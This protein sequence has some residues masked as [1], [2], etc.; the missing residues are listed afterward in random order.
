MPA[1]LEIAI[2]RLD[3]LGGISDS[4]DY[5]VRTFLSPASRLAAGRISH[6]MA[7]LGMEVSHTADGTLRGVLTGANPQAAPLLL[8]SH[9]DTVVDGGK[10]D[11]PLGIIA[12]LAALENL[13]E[14]KFVL[15]F[16]VHVLAFSDEEGTRFQTTY[17]GSSGII[18]PLDEATLAAV[19]AN[20]VTIARAVA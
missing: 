6:W 1:P 9:Y 7:D 16:P 2:A 13:R 4:A 14:E 12:A 11:G 19:D 8:G 15:P 10:Y 3:E 18:G 17:L 20:G 5:L